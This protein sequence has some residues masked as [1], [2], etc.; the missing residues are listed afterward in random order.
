VNAGLLD[1]LQL[2]PSPI[3][4]LID[5]KTTTAIKRDK[6]GFLWIGTQR[7]LHRYNG[8][9]LE[10]FSSANDFKF[11]LPNSDISGI[12][13]GEN[14][15]LWISSVGGGLARYDYRSKIFI[16]PA[17]VAPLGYLYIEK[18]LDSQDEYIWFGTR[19]SGVGAYNKVS[20]TY[21]EWLKT[22]PLNNQIREITDLTKHPSGNIW[23][24]SRTGLYLIE[25]QLESITRF[26]PGSEGEA[27]AGITS[28]ELTTKNTLLVGTS[29]G[30]ILL[31]DTK[32]RK[33]KVD[34]F[35]A[36]KGIRWI[37]DLALFEKK[38]WA[39][40]DQGLIAIESSNPDVFVTLREDN[41]ALS[42]ND[43][44]KLW[45]DQGVL[46]VGTYYGID[47][48]T[49][50]NFETFNRGNSGVFNEVLSFTEDSM[51]RLWVGTYDGVFFREPSS[52]IHMP[53]HTLLPGISFKD[54]RVMAVAAR[55][56]KL[57][58]G[59]RENGVQ[60]LDLQD[61]SSSKVV[62]PGHTSTAV[63]TVLHSDNN[64][65]WI[66]TYEN[67]LYKVKTGYVSSQYDPAAQD[68]SY[69]SEQ[70]ITALIQLSSGSILIG[71]AGGLYRY[72][73]LKDEFHSIDLEKIGAKSTVLVL[74]MGQSPNGDLWIGTK[75]NGL[76]VLNSHLEGRTFSRVKID[77]HSAMQHVV[78]WAI[79]FDTDGNAWLSTTEGIMKMNSSGKLLNTYTRSN[80]LQGN[81]FNF[82]A[83]FSDKNGR[84]YFG[85]SNGYTVFNPKNIQS[86][87]LPPRIV[88]T[89]INIAGRS[90]ELPV[91][92]QE[93][94]KIELSHED[95]YITFMFSALDFQDPAKNQYSYKLEG[96]DR[97]WIDNDTQ[98]SATYTSLPPGDYIFRV[99]GANSAGIWNNEGVSIGL[100]VFPPP[101][102]SWWAL[103][104]YAV[105]LFAALFFA[106]RA[107]DIRLIAK[108]T[109]AKF[110]EVQ[111]A[112]NNAND[113]LQEQLEIQ[114]TLVRSSHRHNLETLEV[115]HRFIG[116]QADFVNDDTVREAIVGNQHRVQ[117]LSILEDCMVYQD[118]AIFTNLRRYVDVIVNEVLKTSSVP[119][120]TITTINEVESQPI[121]AR[122][123]TPAALIIYELAHNCVRHAF[124]VGNHAN[125]IRISMVY[126]SATDL[127]P[128]QWTLSV[129]DSGIGLPPGIAIHSPE[130]TGLAVV[131]M[132]VKELDGTLTAGGVQG[133][134]FLATFPESTP[135]QIAL[136]AS[137]GSL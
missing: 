3:A 54:T 39:A 44:T 75:N 103:L 21:E 136:S 6:A 28:L 89:E 5:Q 131:A 15:E 82:G 36:D 24:G 16:T 126:A 62:F 25:P 98:N 124:D 92:L 46:W 120:E 23:V 40:T 49:K 50:S 26:S 112:A 51:N 4:N 22:H 56:Q 38:V 102:V 93:L 85:G 115:V 90:P 133:T 79:E 128:G 107:Y 73:P 53:I 48:I 129:E 29:T 113:E 97:D 87:S 17:T 69:L 88:L 9:A 14:G 60:I 99:R 130:S 108:N 41:S 132:L 117:A 19:D 35:F 94:E 42:N 70:T 125:F 72:I 134:R 74:S 101:W 61:G 27:A 55:D 80:G 11:W 127:G 7:G 105:C 86:N 30:K 45:K 43:V 123:A 32:N 66:G 52:K 137:F 67:G 91:P 47:M 109:T 84:I 20:Q 64:T 118:D 8:N 63:T 119:V 114:D 78:A 58:L 76:I 12:E 10:T 116:L 104:I 96:F 100:K 33:F 57:W 71:T 1:E 18:L 106:K 122:I 83:S 95:Y 135:Q 111:E 59:F 34:Q 121:P 13:L 2:Y 110:L 81:D 65:T 31:F 68:S 77:P 37:T